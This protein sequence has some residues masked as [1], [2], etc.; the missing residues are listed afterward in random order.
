M[1]EQSEGFA[2]EDYNLQALEGNMEKWLTTHGAELSEER[3][4]GGVRLTRAGESPR[5]AIQG[6][7][8]ARGLHVSPEV[9]AQH[10]TAM[11]GDGE[12]PNSSFPKAP[13]VH[14]SPGVLPSKGYSQA[15]V[16]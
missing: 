15:D 1:G 8:L 5:C 7:V 6:P 12:P 3:G 9:S 14:L 10:L 11:L 2:A 16:S 13:Q 4:D